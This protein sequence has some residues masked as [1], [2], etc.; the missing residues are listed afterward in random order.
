MAS[1]LEP[2]RHDML[3][4]HEPNGRFVFGP[5]DGAAQIECADFEEAL[6]SAGRFAAHDRRNLWY[7]GA[8][9]S[10]R[11]LVDIFSLR[12]LWNEFVEQPALRLTAP[13]VQRFL[14]CDASTC[15]SVIDVLVERGFLE[16]RSDGRY[17]KLVG[18]HRR[19]QPL[20]M[21]RAGDTWPARA[22]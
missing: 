9:G 2:D 13:Q 14:G 18:A 7:V 12:R 20:L 5:C 11:P 10:R 16:C 3:I 8:G 21:K 1:S 4:R 19:I 15:S 22:A 17:H 6:R